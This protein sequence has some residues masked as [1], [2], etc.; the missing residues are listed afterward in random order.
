MSDQKKSSKF[1]RNKDWCKTYRAMGRREKN[2]LAKIMRHIKR[3]PGDVGG[4]IRKGLDKLKTVGY[5]LPK[6]WSI[7]AENKVW[8]IR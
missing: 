7:D 2:K 6:T 5:H 1:G 4:G 3:H 8:E